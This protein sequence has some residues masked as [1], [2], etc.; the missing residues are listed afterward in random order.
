MTGDE[1]VLR[2]AEGSHGVFTRQ[3]ALACGLTERQVEW[4]L[5]TGPGKGPARWVPVLPGVY[6]ARGT[7]L[8]FDGRVMAA[9]LATDGC[10]SHR[11][12]AQLHGWPRS[13]AGGRIHVA[14]DRGNARCLVG[15]TV[16]RPRDLGDTDRTEVRGIPVTSTTRTLLDLASTGST[17]AA[18]SLVDEAVGAGLVTPAHLHD[19]AVALAPGRRN[20][21]FVA[22]L[23]RPDGRAWFRSWLE[24][25]AAAAFDAGG[26]PSPRWNA[27]IVVDGRRYEL[28]A[29][30]PRGRLDV[31]VDGAA[32]HSSPTE[33]QRDRVRDRDLALADVL[34][35]RFGH[36]EIVDHP[37]MVVEQ[38]ARALAARVRQP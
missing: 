37:G 23:T 33:R 12:A 26:L 35:L 22:R 20:V 38:V 16:H 34:V 1:L 27:V 7:P 17:S 24:R 19:R 6:R 15:V 14:Q 4:R 31:E 28:D 11:T 29:W 3:Q 13:P 25:R 2:T 8:T 36:R 10:A 30:W 5:A 21:G 32:F 18:V 9:C